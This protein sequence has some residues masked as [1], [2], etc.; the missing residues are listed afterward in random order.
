[1]TTSPQTSPSVSPVTTAALTE[2]VEGYLRAWRSNART[3]ITALFSDNAEY[4]ETP[5]DTEWVGLEEIVDGWQGRWD[6]QAGGWDFEWAIARTEGRSAVIMGIG[7]YTK[8]GDFDNVWTLTFDES[9]LCTRFEMVNT[10][11]S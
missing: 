11:R 1:M 6:W 7:H 2:W 5:Y 4:H 3:D 9:G 10:E 8:L